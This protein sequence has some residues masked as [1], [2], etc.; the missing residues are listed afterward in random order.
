MKSP[1]VRK[2]DPMLTSVFLVHMTLGWGPY[3]VFSRESANMKSHTESRYAKSCVQGGCTSDRWAGI[4]EFRVACPALS[5]WG[6]WTL[7]RVDHSG[8]F[9]KIDNCRMT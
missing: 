7:G 2:L 8:S 3:G 5:R 1:T 9:M 6:I 4:D